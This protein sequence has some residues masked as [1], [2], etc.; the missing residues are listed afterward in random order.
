[1]KVFKNLPYTDSEN[2]QQ[3]LNIYLPDKKSF[4]VFVF[5]HGGGLESES[6]DQTLLE[7]TLT[8]Y[9]IA[10]VSVDY[11]MYPGASYP[12]FIKDAAAAVAWTKANIHKYG[13]CEKLCVGGSSAGAY[14]SMMLCFDYRYLAPYKITPDEIDSFIHDAGQTTVHFNV[15][16]ERG[17]DTKR[18]VVDEAA[19][20]YHI[21]AG[22]KY[23]P[24]FFVVS[25]NDMPARI[26][27]TELILAVLKNNGHDMSKVEYRIMHGNHVS[28]RTEFDEI[29]D[30]VRAKLYRDFILK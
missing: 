12:D 27:E 14:L 9:G 10:L 16:R 24:M 29:G 18:I 6:K 25:D 28:Y 22:K 4:P 23:S 30:N 15:L 1:M 7:E 2:K 13:T 5:F 26:Q 21:S 19:P 3:T 17:I 20:L 8:K 11:R